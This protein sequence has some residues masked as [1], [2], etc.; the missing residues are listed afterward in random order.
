MV[1]QPVSRSGRER[2]RGLR[3]T[4]GCGRPIQ[5]LETFEPRWAGG[6]STHPSCRASWPR[7]HGR[8]PRIVQHSP[9]TRRGARQQRGKRRSQTPAARRPLR[10]RTARRSTTLAQHRGSSAAICSTQSL[11][12]WFNDYSKQIL[13]ASDRPIMDPCIMNP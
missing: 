4:Q 7:A 12:E 2:A 8:Q 9:S 1:G 5:R 3:D 13:S 11:F 10:V 6:R